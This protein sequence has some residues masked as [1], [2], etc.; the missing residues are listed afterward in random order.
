MKIEKG[1][2]DHKDD[3]TKRSLQEIFL[4]QECPLPQAIINL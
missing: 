1:V 3:K 2:N 4:G